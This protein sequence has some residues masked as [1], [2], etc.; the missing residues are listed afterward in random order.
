[1]GENEIGLSKGNLFREY[2]L[3][4]FVTVGTHEQSFER[5]VKAV[6]NYKA[7]GIIQ[8]D[9][10]IQKGYTDYCPKWCEYDDFLS[11]EQMCAKMCAADVIISHGG[12]STF[13]QALS[14][15][16]K[17]IVVPR[18]KEFGEHVNNHQLEFLEKII[19]EGYEICVLKDMDLLPEALKNVKN[20]K[21]FMSRT[22]E[23]CRDLKQLISQYIE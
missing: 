16:K 8:E 10:F 5:L 1:M 17:L 14:L 15:A 23:F 21:P 7:Q 18:Q 3:M 6:D 11:Y 9:V 22:E 2:I 4:I 13:M 12:P 19:Y 20:G